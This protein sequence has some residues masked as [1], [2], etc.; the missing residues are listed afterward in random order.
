MMHA[1]PSDFTIVLLYAI[2]GAIGAQAGL[3]AIWCV[4]APV[5]FAKRF[6]VGVGT[7]LFLFGA[8]AVGHAAYVYERAY[9]GPDYWETVLT[10]LLCLP[11]L[12]IAVQLPLWMMRMWC[13]WRILYRASPFRHAGFE[14]FGIRDL[15]VATGMVAVALS[16]AQLGISRGDSPADVALLP[17]VIGAGVAAGISL[18]VTL[19]GVVATLRA[20]R[21]WLALPVTLLLY[22]IVVFGFIAIITAIEGRSPP[23]EAYYGMAGVGG[24]CFA[25]LVGVMLMARGL[26]YRL[27][28]GRRQP[29][30]RQ[31][32]SPDLLPCDGPVAPVGPFSEP[33]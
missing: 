11:L 3:H 24:S 31:S 28:W 5:G 33:D 20:R 23:R 17:L 4:L 30:G 19:P 18:I 25:C 29:E 12:A 26:G 22:M 2:L 13:G 14:A 6:A 10:A 8:W 21:R 32:S 7:G 16:A 15:L 27:L 9:Y 1:G